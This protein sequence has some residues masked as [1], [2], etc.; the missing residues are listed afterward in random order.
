MPECC[1]QTSCWC[2]L[3]QWEVCKIQTVW[4]Q[5]SCSIIHRWKNL[6]K[7]V[8]HS[9]A[10]LWSSKKSS[11]KVVLAHRNEGMYHMFFIVLPLYLRVFVNM[12]VCA[13]DNRE[14]GLIYFVWAIHE[15]VL[16]ESLSLMFTLIKPCLMCK[17]QFCSSKDSVTNRGQRSNYS[18]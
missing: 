6:Q 8:L 12:C 17:T 4:S 16:N 18:K 13:C 5:L 3:S 7:W 11:C 9:R 2:F 1:Y 14:D 15:M 10:V